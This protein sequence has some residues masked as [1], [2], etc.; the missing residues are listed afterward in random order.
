MGGTNILQFQLKT[1][2]FVCFAL[3]SNPFKIFF[4]FFCEEKNTELKRYFPT[5]FY[6]ASSDGLGIFMVFSSL[7]IKLKAKKEV[8]FLVI[9]SDF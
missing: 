1:F 4:F 8:F 7:E 2:L 9:T 6:K 5:Y 3:K